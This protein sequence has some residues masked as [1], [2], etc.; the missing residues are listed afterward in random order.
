MTY[1]PAVAPASTHVPSLRQPLQLSAS[2]LHRWLTCP[3]Q[4]FYENRL[5]VQ[6]PLETG[7]DFGNWIHQVFAEWMHRYSLAPDP[8]A[9]FSSNALLAVGMEAL[10]TPTDAWAYSPWGIV[11]RQTPLTL[12]DWQTQ[13][14]ACVRDL[15]TQ[16]FFARRPLC[17]LPEHGISLELT[18]PD[19]LLPALQDA[20]AALSIS[21]VRVTGRIDALWAFDTSQG[22]VWWV[23]DLKTS[24]ATHTSQK[25]E[26]RQA[27]LAAALEP[28]PVLPLSDID[29]LPVLDRAALQTGSAL[30]LRQYQLPFYALAVWQD[31]RLQAAMA[32]AIEKALP[33]TTTPSPLTPPVLETL[34]LQ[35]VR[36]P[37]DSK[38]IGSIQV[39]LPVERLQQ[40]M[41]GLLTDLWQHVVLPIAQSDEQSAARA[42]QSLDAF[43]VMPGK[44]CDLCAFALACEGPSLVT[45]DT[46][47]EDA[48]DD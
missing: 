48:A 32:S 4:Y 26:T 38:G 13:W 21:G 19:T 11:Q 23:L 8:T 31:A 39:A 29:A 37:A 5:R 30:A 46:L 17:M 41:P 12:L 16:G 22:I 45:E 20:L 28:L 10:H 40:A 43:P 3:R 27:H 2:S 44:A 24:A 9:H 36:T 1:I 15:T 34:A 47:A 42:A 25:S 18:P 6:R 7:P 14:Q 33:A 35:Y